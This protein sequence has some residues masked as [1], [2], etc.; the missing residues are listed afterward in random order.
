V[1]PT[2]LPEDGLTSAEGEASELEL[3][4][5]VYHLKTLFDVGQEIGVL[6]GMDEIAKTLLT[7]VMGTFGSLGGIV[8]LV[9]TQKQCIETVARRGLDEEIAEALD[10][11]IDPETISALSECSEIEIFGDG[12]E[13]AAEE[14]CRFL[15]VMAS[16]KVRIWVPFRVDSHLVGG[17]G[18]GG[19]ILS[20]PYSPDDQELL[21]TLAR[22]GAVAMENAAYVER[23]RKDEIVRTNLSRYLSPQFVE[24]VVSHDMELNLGGERKMVTVL[25]SDIR[26][27]TSIT[28]ARPPDQLVAVLNEYFTAMANCVFGNHGIIDKYI[29]DAIMVTFGSL[30]EV[31]NPADSAVRAAIGMMQI[32]P[33]LN[34]KWRKRFDGFDIQIGVGI[35]TGEAFIGNIGSPERMEYTAI[36]DTVNVASR[37]SGIAKAGQIIVGSRTLQELENAFRYK[38]HPPASVKGKSDKLEIFEILY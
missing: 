27:F 30:V 8:A 31:E 32:L 13:D 20:E 12:A 16:F 18:L 15:D 37:F 19:K 26:D 10:C 21:H 35:T 4:R 34:E 38:D 25:F 14:R 33:G 9:D 6:K 28:E 17:I 22:Q 24:K 23:M 3:Q 2:D 29:G 11:S 7:M 5:R 1:T 36:G